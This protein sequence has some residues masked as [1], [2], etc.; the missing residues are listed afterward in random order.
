MSET[1]GHEKRRLRKKAQIVEAAIELFR[2]HGFSRVNVTEIAERAG[3]SQVT[4]YKYFESKQ[5]LIR[6]CIRDYFEREVAFYDKL[7]TAPMPFSDRI[8]TIIRRKLS[9]IHDFNGE[10]VA[11]LIRHGQEYIDEI[12]ELRRTVVER[13]S[14]PLLEE[15]RQN[16]HL[17]AHITNEIV[18]T[19]FDIVATGIVHSPSYRSLQ[20][21]G[22]EPLERIL[23]LSVRAVYG[24]LQSEP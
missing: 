5:G 2:K 20:E 16:G 10:L 1:T 18:A 6:V 17:P 19:F 23:E 22:A 11:E 7:I 12:L 13:I 24:S 14:G 8:K 3:V 21:N 4:V 9:T 15:A